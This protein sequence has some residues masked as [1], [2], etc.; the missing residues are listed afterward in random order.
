MIANKRYT[1]DNRKKP[2]GGYAELVS[3][4]TVF[5]SRYQTRQKPCWRLVPDDL[6]FD[7]EVV[8]IHHSKPR[9]AQEKPAATY[10]FAAK[11]S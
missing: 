4:G 8:H 3:A 2:L 5:L 6:Q 1:E 11:L 7:Y 9:C 10:T